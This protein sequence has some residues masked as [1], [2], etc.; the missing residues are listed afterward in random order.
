MRFTS[1]GG[2]KRL[3]L[4]RLDGREREVAGV[5]DDHVRRAAKLARRALGQA[6]HRVRVGDVARNWDRALADLR[7]AR[8]QLVRRS[9]DHRDAHAVG[10]ERARD[11]EPDAARRAADQRR[12]TGELTH[13]PSYST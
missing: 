9:R 2:A 13:L 1:S 7:R 12:A 11:L 10:R 3:G 4:G 5:V 8:A 6:R